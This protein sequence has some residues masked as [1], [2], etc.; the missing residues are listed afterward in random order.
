MSE[1]KQ[2]SI[3]SL[4]SNIQ[5]GSYDRT[6]LK[7]GIAHIGVGAFHRAHQAIYLD[8]VLDSHKEDNQWGL[9]GIGL[10]PFDAPM[11]DAMN[12]QDSLY[13]V[14]ELTPK[15]ERTTRLVQCMIDYIY[16]PGNYEAVIQKLT[17]ENIKIVSLTITEGGYLMDNRGNFIKTHPSVVSD[18]SNPTQPTSAFG[19]IIEALSRRKSNGTP[20]FTIMSCDNLRHNGDQAKKACLSFARERD[21]ELSKWIEENVTFP[22]GMV[23]RITPATT[24]QLRTELNAA[25]GV[26][27]KAPVVAE[28]FIQWVLEDNFKYGRPKWESVGVTLTD[29]VSPYEEAKIRLLNGSHQML[30]YPSFLA[31]LRRV[32][33]ALE[34]DLFRNYL[35]KFLNEDSGPHLKSIPGM[36]LDSYK[37]ILLDRFSNKAIGDQLARL[38]LDGGSKIPGFLLPT[39]RC[40]LEKYGRCPRL[41]YLLAT[42]NRYIHDLKDDQGEAFEL[43]EP[44]AMALLEPIIANSDP[45]ALLNSTDLV[46]EAATYPE[47]VKE[48]LLLGEHIKKDGCRKTLENLDQ[49]CPSPY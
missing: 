33:I 7:A 34:D 31:G 46:G 27:D 25:S 8:R 28:D 37:K 36:E 22:N 5:K 1:L 23:D 21:E 39:I 20:A 29:N 30:S 9:V 42:Y 24:P 16:A 6:Q 45:M 2:S 48:Y 18:L 10:L 14:T 49:I 47:F 19:I 32:D 13:T 11:R 35:Q 12:A 38:C 40:N 41:A 4:P 44:N 43:R 26:E 15:G 3:T 17:E